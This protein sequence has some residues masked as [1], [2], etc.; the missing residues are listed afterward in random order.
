M[1]PLDP[2]M[3]NNDRCTARA[4][5]SSHYSDNATEAKTQKA[6]RNVLGM[7]T[8]ELL[9]IRRC[10]CYTSYWFRAGYMEARLQISI[11]HYQDISRKVL[12][13]RPSIFAVRRLLTQDRYYSI[14]K[15]ALSSLN[16]AASAE[17][18]E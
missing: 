2:S 11:R 15:A 13:V 18:Y 1:H 17:C 5:H 8:Y 9:W 14:A 7:R 6:T 4:V 16:Y 10:M 3:N 12:A